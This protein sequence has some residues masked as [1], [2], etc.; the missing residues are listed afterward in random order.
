V[1]A[2]LSDRRPDFWAILV[3]VFLAGW[4]GG[5]VAALLWGLLSCYAVVDV[6]LGSRQ[7]RRRSA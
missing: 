2:H 4:L 7:P 6:L 5:A 1:Q 3:T